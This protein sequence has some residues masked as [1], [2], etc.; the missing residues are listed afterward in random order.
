MEIIMNYIDSM[1]A[2]IPVTSET[3]RLREDITA[4][5]TDKYDELVKEGKSG[6]EAIGTVIS[7]FGN[8]DEVLSEMGITRVKVPVQITEAP[9]KKY[10]SHVMAV[11]LL[12]AAGAGVIVL[13][14]ALMIMISLSDYTSIHQVLPLFTIFAGI[15]FVFA[16]LFIRA[17]FKQKN[18]EVPEKVVDVLKAKYKAKRSLTLKLIFPFV[19]I[20]ALVFTFMSASG[21]FTFFSVIF[22]VS[23]S[24]STGISAFIYTEKR[25]LANMIGES[26]PHMNAGDILRELTLPYF[27]FV[28]MYVVARYDYYDTFRIV[29]LSVIVYLVAHICVGLFDTMKES[30]K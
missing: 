26:V 9:E 3:S 27:M 6:N 17:G 16:S 10:L 15:I 23:V 5:M 7:E 11:S 24:T 28:L 22:M 4:N 2:G 1:F 14:I 8:I 18:G 12:A 19:C 13:G 20:F 30:D 21:G 29:V 25:T